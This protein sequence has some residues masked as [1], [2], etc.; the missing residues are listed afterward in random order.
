MELFK[1]EEMEILL[2]RNKGIFLATATG[3]RKQ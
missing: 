3:Y 2:W 1:V